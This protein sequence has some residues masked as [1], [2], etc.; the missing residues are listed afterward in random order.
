MAFSLSDNVRTI[1][2]S[3]DVNQKILVIDDDLTLQEMCFT[4]LERIGYQCIG[5]SNGEMGL[6]EIKEEQPDLI[7]LDFKMS[8]IDGQEVFERLIS[9]K[10]YELYKNTPVIML[11][12]VGHDEKLQNELL[13]RGISAYL[14]KPFG[15]TELVNVIQNVLISHQIKMHNLALQEEIYRSNRYL[16]LIIDH[17]PLGIMVVDLYGTITQLN[18]FFYSFF[19]SE[20][21]SDILG[22]SILSILGSGRPELGNLFQKALSTKEAC[23]IPAIEVHSFTGEAFNLNIKCV[24]MREDPGT[25][26]GILSIWE[27]VTQAEKRAY[28]LS[29]LRQIGEAMQ[30]VLDLDIL[31]HLIL[32]SITAGCALGF[33]RSII[34]LIN[35]E[36]KTLEG[37]MGVGPASEHEAHYIWDELAKDHDNL[38][39]FLTRFGLTYPDYD[40]PFNNGVRN[41]KINLE[42]QTDA[43]ISCIQ[44]KRRMWI[45]EKTDLKA[46][47]YSINDN[48]AE[49]FQPQ[50]FAIVPIIAKKKVLGAVVAD[51]KY[52]G[53]PLREERIALLELLANQAGLAI[54]NAESYHRL[55][56]EVQERAEA[57][58]QLQETQDKL[59]RSEQLATIGNMATHVAHEIR[60]PLTAIGGFANSILKN[61]KDVESVESGAKIIKKEVQRLE[62]ILRN[63]LDFRKISKPKKQKNNLNLVIEEILLLQNAIIDESI[64]LRA[65]LSPLIPEFDFDE[66]QIKQALMNVITNSITSINKKGKIRLETSQSDNVVNI[67]IVDSGIGMDKETL[68]NIFNPFF[69]TRRDGTGLGLAV[70]NRIVEEHDGRIEVT[71]KPGKGTT[72]KIVLPVVLE[73][74]LIDQT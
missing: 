45:K 55:E 12:G 72:F 64:D 49:F 60:N 21:S 67:K 65:D 25:I 7:L 20:N 26:T 59:V 30:N 50:E 43:L 58:K 36:T 32:T 22:Q 16:E 15:I 6:A 46:D 33:S 2:S 35:E 4:A 24:P 5:A 57:L 18:S 69:T 39:E 71:S 41:L 13:A 3:G 17:A 66:E 73:T 31:L 37:R 62:N 1:K 11:T 19:Q 29:I 40:N 23:E 53:V 56:E 70:T 44:N 34:F 68:D 74:T 14:A 54:E 51:N 63:V 10:E 28:E 42:H 61:P 52:S 47:G 8:G 38:Q 48:F 27:D 9:S